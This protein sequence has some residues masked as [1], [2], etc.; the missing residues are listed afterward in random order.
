ML[1]SLRRC[2]FQ[3][4]L[5]TGSG[6]VCIDIVAPACDHPGLPGPPRRGP[7]ESCP[8]SPAAN[9]LEKAIV[10]FLR[11]GRAALPTTRALRRT[12]VKDVERGLALALRIEHY[13]SNRET[14]DFVVERA[15]AMAP[16]IREKSGVWYRLNRWREEQITQEAPDVRRLGPALHRLEQDGAI[17]EDPAR[18]LH[19]L[20]RGV[21]RK[22]EGR[23]ACR[24]N[25]RVD[26]TQEARRAEELCVVGQGASEAQGKG[27]VT[28]GLRVFAAP[29]CSQRARKG[30]RLNSSRWHEE[31]P[32]TCASPRSRA[33]RT[34]SNSRFKVRC[35]CGSS[36]E[37]TGSG[38]PVADSQRRRG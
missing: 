3:Q 27:P 31:R 4:P 32:L 7:R 23:D 21:P 30:Q 33:T 24:G 28:G 16:E 11:T 8:P 1:S 5:P 17:R 12:G 36:M 18:S 13:T 14:K 22:R 20:R 10:A 25:R 2:C 19:Q 6:R 34:S 26:G 38:H 37:S 35:R 29:C 15:R 9:E